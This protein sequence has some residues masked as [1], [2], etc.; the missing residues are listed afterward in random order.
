MEHQQQQQQH[1]RYPVQVK[2]EGHIKQPIVKQ[3][4]NTQQQQQKQQTSIIKK[5]QQHRGISS[6]NTP[7]YTN[8][9]QRHKQQFPQQVQQ[10]QQQQ[11]QQEPKKR[12][13]DSIIKEENVLINTQQSPQSTPISTTP[14]EINIIP[15]PSQEDGIKRVKKKR[16]VSSQTTTQNIK[17]ESTHIHNNTNNTIS[18]EERMKKI[19]GEYTKH[20]NITELIKQ[21]GDTQLFQPINQEGIGYIDKAI[22]NL[23]DYV[24]SF[25]QGEIYNQ[26][27]QYCSTLKNAIE[28]SNLCIIFQQK[29]L[30][31]YILNCIQ[32]NCAYYEKYLELHRKS[33]NS[34]QPIHIIP[35]QHYSLNNTESPSNDV[36]QQLQQQQQPQTQQQVI[37]NSILKGDKEKPHTINLRK[38]E[39]YSVFNT[40]SVNIENITVTNEN[41]SIKRI[42]SPIT[43][44]IF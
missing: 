41:G 31:D 28:Y 9:Q 21:Y 24:Y 36:L 7:L 5:E 14:I 18:Y 39:P 16:V 4:Y 6:N 27:T 25:C 11:Q 17:T 37:N 44:S 8:Q 19:M 13:L 12:K 3:E 35:T 40:V 33:P 22:K 15:P 30:D 23:C 43:R 2:Q 1:H 29:H 42:S 38:K 10:A 20:V 32:Y 26:V 34:I